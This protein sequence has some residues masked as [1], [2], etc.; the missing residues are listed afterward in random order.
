MGGG[1]GGRPLAGFGQRDANRADRAIRGGVEDNRFA[2]AGG[3]DHFRL[4]VFIVLEDRWRDREAR[5]IAETEVVIDRDVERAHSQRD[6]MS[7]GRGGRGATGTGCSART[8]DDRY[9]A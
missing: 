2:G 9:R 8:P 1:L 7:S 3:V 6:L 5:A 4:A